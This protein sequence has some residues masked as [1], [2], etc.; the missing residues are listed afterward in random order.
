LV[1]QDNVI[2]N[3]LGSS[4]A[5]SVPWGLKLLEKLPVLRRIP[6]RLLG[7]GFRPEHVKTPEVRSALV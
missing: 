4:K 7:L 3:V 2:K 5:L 1:V 6:A